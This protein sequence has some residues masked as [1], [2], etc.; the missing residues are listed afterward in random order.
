MWLWV[1]LFL[2]SL[3]I[4]FKFFEL[5]FNNVSGQCTPI[6]IDKCFVLSLKDS[7]IRRNKF[8]DSYNLDIPLEII[9]GYDT[10]TPDVGE[11]YKHLVNPE[12]Y[13]DMYRYDKDLKRPDNTYFNSG[14][15]GCYLGHMDFYKKCF[16][17]NLD[18]AMIFE[19][20]VILDDNFNS[21]LNTAL[22]RLGSDFDVCFFH[23]WSHVGDN[24]EKC[25]DTIKKIKWL[26]STKCYLINVNNMKKYY[27]LFYPIDNHIDNIYEKLVNNGANIYLI[28]LNN[29]KIQYGKSVIAHSKVIDSNYFQ[30][31]DKTETDN[32]KYCFRLGDISFK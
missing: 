28:P 23:C 22:S 13:R 12:K 19:D 7:D 3:I 29:I 2:L 4:F 17:Q 15:L 25:G 6:K 31:L 14:G 16:E 20:N 5:K 8:M 1:V 26:N 11:K 30:Y 10:R 21:E 18:Y 27:N 9:W 32:I 24:V